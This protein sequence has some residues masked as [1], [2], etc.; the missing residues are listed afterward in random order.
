VRFCSREAGLSRAT[1][2]GNDFTIAKKNMSTA[3]SHYYF[4]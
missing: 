1:A 3:T 4:S 2:R